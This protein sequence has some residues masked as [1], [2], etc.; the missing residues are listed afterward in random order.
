[1]KMDS[2]PYS[3]AVQRVLDRIQE[4]SKLPTENKEDESSFV[5]V[6]DFSMYDEIMK[7][8]K[9]NNYRRHKPKQKVIEPEVKVEVA[10]QSKKND[11][12]FSPYDNYF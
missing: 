8:W 5:E 7:L 11:F 10:K 1:M 2:S 4:E 12:S 9:H 6:K 3:N